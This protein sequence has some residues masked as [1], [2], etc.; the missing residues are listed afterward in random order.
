MNITLEMVLSIVRQLLT[1]L[2]SYLITKA[3]I[4]PDAEQTAIGAILALISVIWGIAAKH[5][6]GDPVANKL[7]GK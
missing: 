2:G 6:S 1:F 7:R 5:P 4:T 3:V